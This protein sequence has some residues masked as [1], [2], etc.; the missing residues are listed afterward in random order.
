MFG[1]GLPVPL[2]GLLLAARLLEQGAE[3]VHGTGV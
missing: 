2:L 3:V 1:V